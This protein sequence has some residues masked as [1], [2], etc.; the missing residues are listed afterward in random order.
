MC[1]LD[2]FGK[3]LTLCAFVV[4]DPMTGELMNVASTSARALKTVPKQAS[5]MRVNEMVRVTLS[6]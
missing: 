3:R 5:S 1:I 4:E 2:G 6:P